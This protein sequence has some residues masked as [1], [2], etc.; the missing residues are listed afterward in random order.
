MI[1]LDRPGM[2][3][4]VSNI[5]GSRGINI[6]GYGNRSN[7]TIGYNIIDCATAVPPQVQKEI[8]DQEG[9][10]RTRIIPLGS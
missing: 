4:A 10:I 3:G 1:N 9:V 6:V 2:I 7:G 8:E 5:I